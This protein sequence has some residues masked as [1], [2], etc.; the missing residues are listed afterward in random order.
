MPSESHYVSVAAVTH[1]GRVR[2]KNEDAFVVADLTGG[3]LLDE[4][5][6]A[7]FDVGERGVLLAVSD[8]MGG[9]QA[10]EVASALVVETITREIA[11]APL[12]TPR[13]AALMEAVQRA[14]EAVRVHGERVQARM[15]ATLTAVFVRAGRAYI[16][17]VGDSRAYLL[18][19]GAIA[20]VT[21][22]QS[23][24]QLLVDSGILKPEDAS[25][26]PMRNVILQ[27][28]GHQRE[29]KVALGRLDLRDRDCLVLCSDGLTGHVSDAEIKD[30]VLEAKRP[31]VAA[32][33]LV[34]LANE[35]GGKDNITVI[36]AGIG[37]DLA[38]PAADEKPENAVQVIRAFEPKTPSSR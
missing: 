19:G 28:M 1:L 3:G 31:E 15:G 9:A 34:E 2:E 18:R 25:Q 37:G 36:V 13:D 12:E 10:G 30:V 6:H 21:H 33:R 5:S 20:Q 16:A 11:G 23:M 32:A 22:D 29:I 27:A 17:E 7:R 8:G 35:R 24:V 38:P 14:H 4:R 26:S